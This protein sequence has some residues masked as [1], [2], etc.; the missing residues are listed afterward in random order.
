MSQ[1]QQV[2]QPSHFLVDPNRDGIANALW[3]AN[4]GTLALAGTTPDAFRFNADDAVV[5]ADLLHANVEFGV[6]FPTVGAETPADLVNDIAFGLKNLSLGN[7]G[8]IDVFIDQSED[9]MAFRTY[10]NYGTVQETALT[11]DT[12]WN[13]AL[14]LFR[15][16]WAS[17]HVTLSVLNFEATE[18][19]VLASHARV[20]SRP[21]NPFVH[22]VGADNLDV[23]FISV[24]NAQHS[25]IMLI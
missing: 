22:V 5:R 7:L 20:P 19:E 18:W 23:N 8:K 9:T 4:S 17:S 11:W 3:K 1:K 14:T 2:S 6:K 10:D 13:S 21:L 12:D 16:G 24:A 15:F 25:N